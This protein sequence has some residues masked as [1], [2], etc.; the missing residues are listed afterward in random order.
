M[1]EE[2]PDPGRVRL[3]ALVH[4]LRQPLFAL[5]AR[6]QLARSDGL[7][8]SDIP[9]LLDSLD[10]I[11]QLLDHYATPP[12]HHVTR[13]DL[14][15]IVEQAVA[16]IEE[17]ARDE[18]VELQVELPPAPLVVEGRAIAVRQVVVNL[19]QNAL[20]AVA[21]ADRPQVRVNASE[22][23]ERA[24]VTVHDTGR[25]IADDVQARLFEPFVSTKGTG[26][27]GLG[28]YIAH[29]L[30]REARGMLSI[31]PAEDGGTRAI[32]ELPRAV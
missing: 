22:A 8:I 25:G 13:F 6:L 27:G 14:G 10:H 30:V 9:P 18:G 1:S 32:M 21:E 20:E 26:L 17:R 16:M 2:G 11:G 3:A 15:D 19:L 31:V 23:G 29:E 5:R 7:P 28:L 4:E 12:R 24:R